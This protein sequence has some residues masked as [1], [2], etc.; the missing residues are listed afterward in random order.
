MFEGLDEWE[1]ELMDVIQTDFPKEFERLVI[2]VASELHEQVTGRTP[3]DTSN[4][5]TNW[6]I[7]K[8]V[9]KVVTITSRFLTIPI[10]LNTL[11]S[12]T[13]RKTAR[14]WFRGRT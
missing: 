6:K 9:K 1:K 7:G 14:K 11:S 5:Q 10:M 12:G 4:L 8:I 3:V 2:D 13:G